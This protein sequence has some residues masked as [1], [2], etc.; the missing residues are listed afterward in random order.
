MHQRVLE[1]TVAC[2]ICCACIIFLFA[3]VSIFGYFFARALFFVSN[4]F[5]FLLNAVPLSLTGT[6]FDNQFEN[7]VI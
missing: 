3:L 1:Y 5:Y 7:H 4:G 6:G 2:I